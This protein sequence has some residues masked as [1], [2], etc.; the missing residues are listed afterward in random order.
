MDALPGASAICLIS[1]VRTEWLWIWFV[2]TRRNLRR[3]SCTWHSARGCITRCYIQI[4]TLS[5]PK[6]TSSKHLPIGDTLGRLKRNHGG[7]EVPPCLRCGAHLT[8][9]FANFALALIGQSFTALGGTTF[10]W[11]YFFSN[12]RI[13]PARAVAACSS[14]EKSE[15]LR[16]SC[17]PMPMWRSRSSGVYMPPM[18]GNLPCLRQAAMTLV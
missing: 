9:G 1:G 5:L 4:H 6:R 16:M 13:S 18:P 8:S 17:T 10:G 12:P 15:P 2:S 11:S 14:S 7:Y 3:R